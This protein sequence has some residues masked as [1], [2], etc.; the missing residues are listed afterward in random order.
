M[1]EAY[2]RAP[3]STRRFLVDVE[4][5]EDGFSAS[6]VACAEDVA[7]ERE[8]EESDGGEGGEE[9]NDDGGESDGLQVRRESKHE[10]NEWVQ[11]HPQPIQGGDRGRS[12]P[13]RR[14]LSSS[15]SC[16]QTAHCQFAQLDSFARLA[17]GTNT[18]HLSAGDHPTELVFVRRAISTSLSLSQLA[19]P[20]LLSQCPPSRSASSRSAS[21]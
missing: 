10:P 7:E 2:D 4:R 5:V 16:P 15:A 12:Q 19:R 3:W 21:L 11:S 13:L 8:G 17:A 9:K 18:M 1:E 20:P 14:K 6:W